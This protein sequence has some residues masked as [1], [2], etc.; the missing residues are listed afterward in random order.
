MKRSSVSAFVHS[1]VHYFQ[2][3]NDEIRQRRMNRKM[4]K[5]VSSQSEKDQYI[6][7]TLINKKD[8][9]YAR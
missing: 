2:V 9:Y 4:A 7:E 8:N 6:R 5:I 3:M 1:L